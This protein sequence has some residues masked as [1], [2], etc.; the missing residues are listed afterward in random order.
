[1]RVINPVM[2][3]LRNSRSIL[4]TIRSAPDIVDVK[5]DAEQRDIAT[6]Q[7][8]AKELVWATGCTSWFIETTTG[9]NTIMYPDWQYRFWLRSVFIASNDFAYRKSKHAVVAGKQGVGAGTF[10]AVFAS[11]IIGAGALFL[12]RAV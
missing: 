7:E 6:V 4:P 3:A 11:V 2:K 10:L 8:K 5:A 1:M 12:G 9:R